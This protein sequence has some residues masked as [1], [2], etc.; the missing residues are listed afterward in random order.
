MIESIIGAGIGALGNIIGGSISSSG[1]AAANAQN[2]QIAREQMAFQERMSNT[3][4]QRAMADMKAAGLNPILAYQQGGASTPAGAS[5]HMENAME[6]LGQ[7]VTSASQMARNIAD[8]EKVKADTANTTS[9]EQ[10]NK[11]TAVL[12][13]ANT[14]KAVQDT[15]TSAA[16][17][18]KAKAEAALT[19]E[20][21]GSPAARRA[22]YGSQASSAAANARLTTRQAEDAEKWGTSTLGTN[23]GGFE[24]IGRR[25]LDALGEAGRRHDTERAASAAQRAREQQNAPKPKTLREIN[26]GWFTK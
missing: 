26:P 17:M 8:L 21:L 18:E 15:A 6:G 22:L 1:Q 10:V 9:Q 23:A 3:A 19:T 4:Y 13:K 7:G 14:V 16:Q 11:E 24:R 25:F 12:T 20:E 5:A 2:A